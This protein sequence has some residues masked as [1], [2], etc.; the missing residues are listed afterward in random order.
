MYKPKTIK[1]VV[2]GPEG[3]GKSSIVNFLAGKDRVL[4]KQYR[5]TFACRVVETLK[6]SP[7]STRRGEELTIEFWDVSGNSRYERGWPAIQKNAN[8]V[9]VVYNAEN[10]THEDQVSFWIDKFP[11]A[12]NISTKACMVFAHHLSGKVGSKGHSQIKGVSLPV[13]DTSIE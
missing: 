4:E 7:R 5:P 1:I 8:G 9:I 2:I 3:S 10:I 13:E 11:K 6:E 12:C